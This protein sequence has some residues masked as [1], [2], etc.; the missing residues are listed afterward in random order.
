MMDNRDSIQR[1]E[2][3]AVQQVVT[4]LPSADVEMTATTTTTTALK[5]DDP[6]L[7]AF[8]ESFDADNPK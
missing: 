4:P 8:D 7:V 1:L 3:S 5:Q 6:Y 2:L